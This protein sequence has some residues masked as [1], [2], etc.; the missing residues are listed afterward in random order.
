MFGSEAAIN[1][2]GIK[3][4]PMPI[5]TRLTS[6]TTHNLD[7]STVTFEVIVTG[8]GEGGARS[9]S[10]NYTGWAGRSGATAFK[11]WERVSGVDT[12]AVVVGGG[13]ASHDSNSDSTGADG[14]ESTATYNGELVTAQ[15]GA[16][17]TQG[18]EAS[19]GDV[20]IRG[21]GL[22]RFDSAPVDT[23]SGNTASFWGPPAANTTQGAQPYGAGGTGAQSGQ[24]A[25]DGGNGVVIIL[26]YA[27]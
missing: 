15:G 17:H 14:G 25:G 16:I 12:V 3:T 24:G 11:T 10:A 23:T 5:V 22:Q 7:P 2:G 8:G 21:C 19:G 4:I 9:G 6:S 27:A 13:G 1:R 20:N 18:A 26:E